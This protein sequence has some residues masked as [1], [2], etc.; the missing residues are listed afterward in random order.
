MSSTPEYSGLALRPGDAGDTLV[1][2]VARLLRLHGATDLSGY[3]SLPPGASG[4][5]RRRRLIELQSWANQNLHSARY[6]AEARLALQVLPLLDAHVEDGAW[7]AELERRLPMAMQQA[8]RAEPTVIVAV[9]PP[10]ARPWLL[11]ALLA[12]AIIA[13]GSSYLVRDPPPA[14]PAA[15]AAEVW[16]AEVG[17]AQPQSAEP[18]IPCA[19]TGFYKGTLLERTF[20]LTLTSPDG[21]G[22]RGEAQI[23]RPEL[24]DGEVTTQSIPVEGFC[25]GEYVVLYGS[26]AESLYLKGRPSGQGLSGEVAL[27]DEH[28]VFEAKSG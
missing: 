16:V 4:T 23:Q 27:G 6:G 8:E 13:L 25:A 10:S 1:L 15:P 12:T 22:L 26:G 28:G 18:P 21:A 9:D 19:L 17:D 14:R 5:Q 11:G 3:L 24:T 2:D 7:M 20:T